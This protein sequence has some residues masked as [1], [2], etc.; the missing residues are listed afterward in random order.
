M[1]HVPEVKHFPA[2]GFDNIRVDVMNIRKVYFTGLYERTVT[3]SDGTIRTYKAYIPS[4]ASYGDDSCYVAVPDGVDTAEF[5]AESGWLELAEKKE[6][7]YIL[8][9][10][11]PVDKTWG[12]AGTEVEYIG[13]AFADISCKTGGG[14]RNLVFISDFNWRWMGYGRGGEMVM[15]YALENPMLFASLAV[16]GD[17]AGI[18]KGTLD[19]SAKICYTNHR[20]H[21]YTEW[22][23]SKIPVPVWLIGCTNEGLIRYWK[24]A[25][26]C[27]GE[28][29]ALADGSLYMQN[30]LS[31]NLMTFDQKIGQVKVTTAA[32]SY[33]DTALN[34]KI[35]RFLHAFSRCGMNSPYGNMLYPTTEDSFFQRETIISDN[36][37]REWYIHVPSSY[38]GRTPVPLVIYFH[39][40]GQTGL[41]AMRQGGWWQ[42]GEQKGFITV[43][44]TGSLLPKRTDD[45]LPLCAWHSWH[46]D[47]LRNLDQTPANRSWIGVDKCDMEDR[48]VRAMLEK[49]Y[50]EYNIDKSRMYIT[51]Q[52]NG[53]AMTQMMA[54]KG[55]D[56]FAAAAC[57]GMPVLVAHTPMPDFIQGGEFDIYPVVFTEDHDIASA[58]VKER[59]REALALKG[60]A[61]ESGGFFQNGIHNNMEWKNAEGMPVYRLC[62]VSGQA[63]SWRQNDCQ[64]FWDEWFCRYS[65][66]P[67]SGKILYMGK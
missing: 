56:L 26:D 58:E 13:K 60:I 54:E 22:P 24:T 28:G 32:E 33:T 53:C 18:D 25:N 5:L 3:L 9:A 49:L 11:E 55:A 46:S 50:G 30:P 45:Q 37:E 47:F 19:A 10:L 51:G 61:Y 29:I 38:D 66:D 7:S 6:N 16:V 48:F 21:T 63:H 64:T 23:N 14:F 27:A 62:C 43:C 12:D 59:F 41:I 40:H 17:L 1:S 44:P 65:R 35:N 52:S 8:F 39:G 2:E 57:T 31:A 36:M 67:E 42:Y 4:T 34:E 20:N 15:R